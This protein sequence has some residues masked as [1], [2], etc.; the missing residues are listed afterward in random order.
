MT[1]SLERR[2][3]RLLESDKMDGAP[4]GDWLSMDFGEMDGDEH[5]HYARTSNDGG[6]IWLGSPGTGWH[7]FYRMPDALTL[8]RFILWDWWVVA[9][10]CGLRRKIW[11]FFLHREVARMMMGYGERGG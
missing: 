6:E 5:I 2:I 8:A 11:Y 3:M 4:P 1:R 10:W 9:T 7:V